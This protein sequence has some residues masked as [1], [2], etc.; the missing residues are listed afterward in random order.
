MRT[1][2]KIVPMAESSD[3]KPEDEFPTLGNPTPKLAAP[4]DR[5]FATM[6]ATWA[7]DADEKKF[8]DSVRK[9]NEEVLDMIRKRHITPL[10][11]FHNV[12]RFVEPEEDIEEGAGDAP[13]IDPDEQGWVEVIT[14]RKYK[15]PRAFEETVNRPPTPEETSTNTTVWNSTDDGDSYWR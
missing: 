9:E 7:K 4:G 6:A 8:Q 3:T 14:K 1:S 10:P 15:K 2:S 5:T 11:Q 13:P 12:R